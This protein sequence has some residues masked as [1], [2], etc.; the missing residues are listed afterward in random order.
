MR[1]LMDGNAIQIAKPQ[2]FQHITSI[3]I[4]LD[5]VL[6]ECGHFGNEIQSTFAFFFLQFQRNTTHGAFG[7]PS[8]QVCGISRNFVPDALGG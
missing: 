3:G 2:T 5:R 7:N 6:F 4:D 1:R 8:H